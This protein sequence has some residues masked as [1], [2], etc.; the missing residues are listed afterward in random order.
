MATFT[1]GYRMR[2]DMQNIVFTG[3]ALSA[4]ARLCRAG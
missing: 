4:Q 3:G 2:P 1:N